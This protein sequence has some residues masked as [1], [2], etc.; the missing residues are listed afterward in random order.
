MWWMNWLANFI[1]TM[2]LS[3]FSWACILAVEKLSQEFYKLKESAI[4]TLSREFQQFKKDTSYAFHLYEHQLLGA[5]IPLLKKGDVVGTHH[6][7]PCGS[8]Q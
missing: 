7:P 8:T 5:S 4:E 6:V 1:N 3:S 2:S